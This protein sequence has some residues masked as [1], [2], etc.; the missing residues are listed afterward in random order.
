MAKRATSPKMPKLK[1]NG[2]NRAGS[3][4]AGTSRPTSPV[5]SPPAVASPI[6]GSA[7][8]PSAAAG[9]PSNKRKA[10]EGG[11]G[12]SSKPKK[13]KA[14]PVDG[15]LEDR[16]VIEWL[17]LAPNATTR[18][19]IHHFTPYLTT[20]EKKTNFTKLVK[21]VAMLKNG[22][23]VLRNAYRSAS[24]APEPAANGAA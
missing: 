24:S 16:M 20:E 1:T 5:G 9:K 11:A 15:E 10:E 12:N 18:D 6:L 2:P 3:P 7:S 17:R 21:E 22:V 19:C 4:L 8:P 14:H 23:L 13:R